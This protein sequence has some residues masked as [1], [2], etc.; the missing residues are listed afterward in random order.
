MNPSGVDASEF[1]ALDALLASALDM[2]PAVREPWLRARCG[3]DTTRLERAL[4]LLRRATC[5]PPWEQRLDAAPLRAFIADAVEAGTA[6]IAPTP[7]CCGA[8]RLLEP[9]GRGGMADVHLGERR[10]AGFVQRA[11]IK[12]LA[13]A[14]HSAELIARFEQERRI[15][16]SLDDPRIA[17]LLDG[18]VLADGRPWLA[19]EYVDGERIDV[20]CDARRLD[21]AA[22]VR[23]LREVAA[24]VYSAHRALVVHRDIK[25]ANVMVT[26]AG[27]VK[28]LDFGIAKLLD[29]DL[30]DTGG[31]ATQTHSRALTPQYASPEQLLGKTVTSAADVYQLGLLMVEL[32]AGVRPFHSRSDNLV[33]LAHAVVNEDAPA[34]SLALTR[35]ART[36]VE[37]E[38]ILH[39]RNTTAKR[40]RRQLRGDLDAIAQHALARLPDQRYPSA[41]Q[42]ADD[43]D[44]WLVQRPVR[45]RAPSFGYRLR[46]FASRNWLTSSVAAVLLL[47]LAAYLATV[48]VQ[49]ERIRRESELN[50]LVRDFLVELV[51]EADPR[52]TRTPQPSAERLLDQ[53]LVNARVRFAA[54]PDLLAELLRIG[55]DVKVGRGEY[56]RAAELMGETLALRRTLDPDDPRLTEVLAQYGRT[57]HYTARYADAEAALREAESRWYAHGARGTAWIPMALADVLHSRGE[58]VDAE[59][60]LRRADAAQRRSAAGPVAQAEVARDLG[61]VLRDAGRMPEARVLLAAALS[62]LQR[63]HGKN[64]DSSLAT[65]AALARTLALAGEAAA[66]RAHAQAAMATQIEVYGRNHSVIAISRHTLALAD[67]L[68]GRFEAGARGL[69]EVLALDYASTPPGNVLPAYAHLDRAWLRLAAGRDAEAA[70]DLDAAESTLRSIRVGGHPRWAELQ[71]AR[72]VLSARRGDAEG[73]R[74]AIGRAIAQRETLFGAHHPF[75]LEARRWLRALDGGEVPA[76][77][78]DAPRL[79]VRRLSLLAGSP[80][81]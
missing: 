50:R 34:P 27:H 58:Y 49:S 21:V 22:R 17:R 13:A 47:V 46:R 79:E 18:G 7:D 39:A 81:L 43:L 37:V 31:T 38:T 54:Q 77:A 55:A 56:A 65:Q 35:A 57:L 12:I 75:A 48:L 59:A 32:L 8:W 76:P 40:L 60:L 74:A 73:A 23:L 63:L 72:A 30:A 62:D 61:I 14:A 66:A 71:L 9:I 2:E 52:R 25:P 5:V 44:A 42:F 64:H 51:R 11:A 15:L 45:A 36:A 24:A 16:A 3:A 41:L 10:E 33:E 70:S 28:L 29:P 78:A 69:D 1:A 19:M 26:T 4:D 80:S 20:W 6:A 68:D 67:E 53:G